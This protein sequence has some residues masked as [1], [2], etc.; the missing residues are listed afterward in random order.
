MSSAARGS[1]RIVRLAGLTTIHRECDETRLAAHAMRLPSPAGALRRARSTDPSRC[2]PAADE[3]PA[4]ERTG[5]GHMTRDSGPWDAV[6]AT[7]PES[8]QIDVSPA[9]PRDSERGRRGGRAG[10]LRGA[11]DA[12]PWASR[13]PAGLLPERPGVVGRITGS[14]REAQPHAAGPSR[15]SRPGAR[16]DAR[17]RSRPR[18]KG[19]RVYG[20]GVRD[21]K[22]GLAAMVM[23][24]R[25]GR[26]AAGSPWKATSS[27]SPCPGHMEQGVGAKRVFDAGVTA[28]L[29]VVGEPTGLDLLSTHLGWSVLELTV[30]GRETSTVTARQGVNAAGAS[31]HRDPESQPDALPTRHGLEV[32]A[33][34][35]SRH[36]LLP[37]HGRHPG[38]QSPLSRTSSPDSAR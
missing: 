14:G 24:M 8:E 37:E 25:A 31:R 30:H 29:V 13:P 26:E 6:L 34:V 32:R 19:G 7:V 27:S 20:A 16:L 18:V 21:M 17:I 33:P 38:R 9:D 36:A 35:P 11:V 22:A 28:D 1:A 4:D 2:Q 12:R 10:P 5:H 15:C 23:A 3:R